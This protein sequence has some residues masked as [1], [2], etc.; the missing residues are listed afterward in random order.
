MTVISLI[1]TL[2][3]G[4]IAAFLSFTLSQ[5]IV[6]FESMRSDSSWLVLC[7]PIV[8]WIQYSIK[9]NEIFFPTKIKDLHEFQQ[10]N[11]TFWNPFM[12]FYHFVGSCLSHLVGAS[13]GREGVLVLTMTGFVHWFNL[14]L[15]FWGP[16]AAGIGFSAMTGH[17]L[18][19]V[20]FVSELFQTKLIQKLFVFFGSWVASLILTSLNFK[21]YFL[22]LINTE[23]QSSFFQKLLFIVVFGMISGVIA[24]HFKNLYNKLNHFF[25]KNKPFIF[26]ATVIVSIVLWIPDFR[27]LQ[28]LGF[29]FLTDT[30]SQQPD[31]FL[32]LKIFIKLIV[33]LICV[34]IGLLG[35][36]FI[37]LY[38]VGTS[39]GYVFSHYLSV[40][41]LIGAA[42]GSFTIFAGVSRLKWTSLFLILTI[43]GW[44][45]FISVYLLLTI[46]IFISEKDSLYLSSQQL[47]SH[48]NMFFR[49]KNFKMNI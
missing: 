18:I 24:K 49:F 1:T 10:S 4:L 33:T 41:P 8:V 3:L 30:L 15:P 36:E 25:K 28:S 12:G 23:D 11:L 44:D 38:I 20:I 29:N 14:S 13:V 19:G 16:I 17:T 31:S 7:L 37:P 26:I 43:L 2:L 48:Q 45:H 21:N 34:S 9:N 40:D 32:M 22:V 27:N 6:F 39:L 46:S 42:Y 35:G 47:D 5:V